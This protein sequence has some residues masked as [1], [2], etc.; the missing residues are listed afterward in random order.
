MAAKTEH[1]NSRAKEI[2]IFIGKTIFYFAILVVLVYL[3]S[4]SGIGGASFIYKDFYL[5]GSH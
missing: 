1:Q 2:G 4:Y 3:Y 5:K